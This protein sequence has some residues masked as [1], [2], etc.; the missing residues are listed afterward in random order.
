MGNSKI[1]HI[2][3]ALK[4]PMIAFWVLF[5]LHFLY[6][7]LILIL[8]KYLSLIYLILDIE[9]L[10]YTQITAILI[11]IS[12]MYNKYKLFMISFIMSI[13]NA[14]FILF[15]IFIVIFT[16]YVK[17]SLHKFINPEPWT[18]EEGKAWI[19]IFLIIQKLIYLIPL[20]VIIIYYKNLGKS[21]GYIDP[22]QIIPKQDSLLADEES[23]ENT[24]G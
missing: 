7:T 17:N 22:N 1:N 12:N 4:C 6:L 20:I 10:F 16:F 19:G 3:G 21:S 5:G 11:T 9:T 13:I 23:D 2:S 14:I 15:A 24:L 18:E 8:K